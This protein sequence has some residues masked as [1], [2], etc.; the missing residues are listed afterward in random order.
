MKKS[1]Q[2]PEVHCNEEKSA[3]HTDST[4]AKK[5]GRPPKKAA[6]K[7][8]ES[9]QID[10]SK[11]DAK[12][13]V[14]AAEPKK[15]GRP[16]KTAAAVHADDQEGLDEEDGKAG[17]DISSTT[18]PKKKGRPRKDVA[19][20]E[21]LKEGRKPDVTAEEIDTLSQRVGGITVDDM[22]YFGHPIVG[23]T[24]RR[25]AGGGTIQRPYTSRDSSAI[26]WYDDPKAYFPPE[27]TAKTIRMFPVAA[28]D[29]TRRPTVKWGNPLVEYTLQ[30]WSAKQKEW[31]ERY[32]NIK[33]KSTGATPHESEAF[34]GQ[35]TRKPDIMMACW[36]ALPVTVPS[37]YTGFSRELLEHFRVDRYG[38][39]IC[40]PD[41][42]PDG[43]ANNGSLTFFDVD[44]IFPWCR[45]G[46]SV[47]ENFEAVQ[48]VANRTIKSDN[49]VQS[50]NPVD[51][52]CGIT[53]QQVIS[54]V[55]LVLENYNQE[56]L[57]TRSWLE[58]IRG[59][60]TK[61]PPNKMSYTD[62]QKE[63]RC[64]T[65]GR[66]LMQYFIQRDVSQTQSLLGGSPATK[67]EAKAEAK[68]EKQPDVTVSS[69]AKLVHDPEKAALQAKFTKH[70]IEVFGKSTF[71][72][73]DELKRAGY[74]WDGESAGRKCWTKRV[75]NKL[76]GAREHKYLL[77]LADE[78][79]MQLVISEAS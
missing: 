67:D 6:S 65:D 10:E 49:I 5:K 45:G 19:E 58:Q 40:L 69:A 62:F 26:S 76:D 59:W 30:E 29:A 16:P 23:M 34:R 48:N 9:V 55:D 20:K 43:R 21:V 72:V 60:L 28:T 42:L 78:Y 11:V 63:V 79:S 33:D 14:A 71:S 7:D 1:A 13:F 12:Q 24:Y 35:Q 47:K 77:E 8:D 31:E 36:N 18:E 27:F 68:S 15:K 75:D 56:R 38:N 52:N 51:M 41:S 74:S 37:R 3:Q 54:M 32:P 57:T 53:L 46:R 22:R 44:H 61:S 17:P 2:Q 50:L 66:T 4:E 70:F 73:K 64:S 39:V 25:G